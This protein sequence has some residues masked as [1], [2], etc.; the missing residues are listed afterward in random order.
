MDIP[1]KLKACEKAALNHLNKIA[2]EL[3][4]EKNP[5]FR[6]TASIA[7]KRDNVNWE[8]ISKIRIENR[9]TAGGFEDDEKSISH[10]TIDDK[11]FE[12]LRLIMNEYFG[13]SKGVQ[14][15]FLA[16]TIIK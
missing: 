8:Q 15:A 2:P 13:L 11:D 7:A 12:R 5:G 3:Y 4:Q 10:L 6:W 16:R 1:I 14:K 9:V